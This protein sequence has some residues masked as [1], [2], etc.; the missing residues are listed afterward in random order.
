[1]GSNFIT[2]NEQ[3]AQSKKQRARKLS[4]ILLIFVLLGAVSTGLSVLGYETY[5]TDYHRDVSL[6]QLGMHHLQ[7]A[8]ALL[9]A[10]P[11]NPFDAQAVSQAQHE[12][13]SASLAFVQ[14]NDNLR[15]LPAIAT[16]LPVYGLRLRAA[17]DLLPIAIELSQAGFYGCGMLNLLIA[18]FHN[19]LNSNGQGLTMADFS[20]LKNDFNQIKT[21]R[22]TYINK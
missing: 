7:K 4:I 3:P 20:V 12:F 22:S 9:K 19:P 16:S 5:T 18:R 2:E 8:E 14:V 1:M 11:T 21:A 10:L 15:S 13:A 17:F 6:A